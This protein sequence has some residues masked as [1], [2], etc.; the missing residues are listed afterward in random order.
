MGIPLNH[1]CVFCCFLNAQSIYPPVN[2][3][4]SM[5]NHHVSWLNPLFRLGHVQVRELIES[6][7]IIFMA[8]VSS[9]NLI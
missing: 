5:G 8:I 2:V 1:P 7:P 4:I 3:S 9:G 6:I